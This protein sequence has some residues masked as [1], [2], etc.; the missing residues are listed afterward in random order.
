[1]IGAGAELARLPRNHPT[2]LNFI[3]FGILFHIFDA[4]VNIGAH[5]LKDHLLGPEDRGRKK[6]VV[7][8]SQLSR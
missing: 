5:A 3:L 1:M 8:V 6:S 7:S 4:R 2:K